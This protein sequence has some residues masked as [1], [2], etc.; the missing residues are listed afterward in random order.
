LIA[1]IILVFV[2]VALTNLVKAN[3]E[4]HGCKRKTTIEGA[5][6]FNFFRQPICE[7]PLNEPRNLRPKLY[8]AS[9]ANIGIFV[10]TSLL[11]LGI[12]FSKTVNPVIVITPPS[13]ATGSN[14]APSNVNTSPTPKQKVVGKKKKA[15]DNTSNVSPGESYPGTQ[16][17]N[18]TNTP[19][20]GNPKKEGDQPL[21]NVKSY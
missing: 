19:D 13:A 7:R 9:I 16:N 6:D 12:C 15:N 4:A 2:S 18:A 10:L 5:N 1:A 20:S 3:I 17:N 14:P 11:A 21:G 8:V